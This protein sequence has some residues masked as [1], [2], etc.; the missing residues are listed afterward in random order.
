[1]ELGDTILEMRS[2]SSG[3]SPTPRISRVYVLDANPE[4]ISLI[5]QCLRESVKRSYQ[6]ETVGSLAEALWHVEEVK[7]DVVLMALEM[8]DGRGLYAFQKLRQTLPATPI[9]VFSDNDDMDLG[10]AL[11]RE[12]A[13]DYIDI[14]IFKV[15]GV[16][17]R[18]IQHA[19]QRERT[20]E[21]LRSASLE[22]N[23]RRGQLEQ[24]TMA[25]QEAR[26]TLVDAERMRTIGRLAAGVAHEVKNPLAV[27]RV[28]LDY[29]HMRLGH[30]NPTVEKV[31]Q[32]LS[33]AVN[34]ANKIITGLLDFGA[35]KPLSKRPAD[36]KFMV[37]EA[38]NLT[39]H[40]MIKH[41]VDF[42]MDIPEDLPMVEADYD[43]CVQVLVNLFLNAAHAI[44][45]HGQI[46]VRAK[47]R[48]LREIRGDEAGMAVELV[49][50]DSGPG[51]P[52]KVLPNLFQPFFTTKEKQGTGLGLCVSQMI[53]HMHGGDLSAG[54]QPDSGAQFRLYWPSTFPHKSLPNPPKN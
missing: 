49:V 28:G 7:P 54:N 39:E 44:K 1:M 53:M 4:H 51:I 40:A 36:V 14:K 33:L 15:P 10:E 38:F 23:Q 32:D 46:L 3:A 6:V 41:H 25:L 12:G 21:A 42:T 37:L 16:L 18:I 5:R 9:I 24:T 29:L 2:W 8:H 22:L 27:I 11:I 43:K 26:M 48:P 13:Q 35:P 45:E 31:M 34:R 30:E 52:E 20:R 19:V 17:G 50:E 47:E